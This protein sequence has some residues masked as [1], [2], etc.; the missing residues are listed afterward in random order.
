MSRGLQGVR[1]APTGAEM[2]D[3]LDICGRRWALRV[4][5]ELRGGA[6]NFRGLRAACGEI[7]PG[8]LQS[9]LHEWRRVNVVESIPRLG[10][11]LT[12]RGEQLFQLL[13]PL[14]EWAAAGDDAASTDKRKYVR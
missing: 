11:R 3:L 1:E 8:V 9:R 14:S 7:S 5:W 13:A 4:V 12:V 10:Y 6:M 2:A